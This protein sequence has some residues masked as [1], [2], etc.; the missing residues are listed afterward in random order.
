MAVEVGEHGQDTA[1]VVGA[2]VESELGED[3][4]DVCL[5]GSLAD[6][7][8]GATL[9]ELCEDVAFAWGE[10]PEWPTDA[11][12]VHEQAEDLRVDDGAA[13]RDPVHRIRERI[14]VGD[15]LLEEMATPA[16]WPRPPPLSL[17]LPNAS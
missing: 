11:G 9:G 6:G 1:V 2:I 14:D 10:F 16:G 8:V 15:A 5:D 12:A 3:V 17:A 13:G 4:G 7:P